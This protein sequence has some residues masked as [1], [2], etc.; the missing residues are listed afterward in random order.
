MKARVLK[1]V[2]EL[3]KNNEDIT[4]D[5]IVIQSL[6]SSGGTLAGNEKE[7]AEILEAVNINNAIPV[8]A[9]ENYQ[10]EIAQDKKEIFISNGNNLIYGYF[11]KSKQAI[12]YDIISFP[13]YVR[14]KALSL[15]NTLNL[16][17]F[18]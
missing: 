18:Y 16:P 6:F 12:F 3:V 5:N 13:E 2:R 1:I 11:D 7:I 9:N 15:C 4:V 8:W 10:I 17:S 14:N